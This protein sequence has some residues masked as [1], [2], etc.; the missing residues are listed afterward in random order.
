MDPDDFHR[1]WQVKAMTELDIKQVLNDHKKWLRGAGG[2]QAYLCGAN[3]DFA[4]LSGAD[5]RS[6]DLRGA[7]LTDAD[8]SG[9]DLSNADLRGANL[10]CASLRVA[11]LRHTD[12]QGADLS[13]AEIYTADLFG[14]NITGAKLS[15][16]D[17]RYVHE[18]IDGGQRLDGRR[19]VGWCLERRLMVLTERRNMTLQ[20]YRKHNASRLDSR[21]REETSAILD[22]IEATARARG[23]DIDLG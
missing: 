12:L 9:A 4:Q 2:E 17:L 11:T 19:F 16:T 6:A 14:V 5:L 21:L 13:Y 23:W 20:E 3:L 22:R 18:L 7:K 8:L 10:S 1:H 15:G